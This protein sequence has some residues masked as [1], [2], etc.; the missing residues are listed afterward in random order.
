MNQNIGLAQTLVNTFIFHLVF[1]DQKRSVSFT[2][3]LKKKVSRID[4]TNVSAKNIDI[5][6]ADVEIFQSGP[7]WWN[8]W[9]S[10]AGIQSPA[11]KLPVT[12][13]EQ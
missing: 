8:D 6:L 10:I 13:T 3:A 5:H 7:K 1:V 4:Y 9:P 12:E 11:K 2:T